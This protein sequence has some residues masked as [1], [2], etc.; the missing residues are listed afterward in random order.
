MNENIFIGKIKM[1]TKHRSSKVRKHSGRYTPQVQ[2]PEM[3]WDEMKISAIEPEEEYD[4]WI[5]QRD[6]F[7]DRFYYHWKM[8]DREKEMKRFKSMFC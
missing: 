1:P 4:E 3:K 7:R 5:S 6:G 8:K 2:S